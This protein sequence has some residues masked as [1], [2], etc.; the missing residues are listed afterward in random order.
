MLEPKDIASLLCTSKKINESL[1]AN[2]MLWL[3]SIKQLSTKAKDSVSMLNEKLE[4]LK[5]DDKRYAFLKG[6]EGATDEDIKKLIDEYICQ[7]KRL[8]DSIVKIVQDCK[9]FI[10]TGEIQF[11]AKKVAIATP[12]K[13]AEAGSGFFG[14]IGGMLGLGAVMGTSAK[15]EPLK[16][17]DVGAILATIVTGEKNMSPEGINSTLTNTAKKLASLNQDKMSR[18]VVTL[19]KCFATLYKATLYFY[20]EAR[21]VEKLKDFLTD[22]FEQLKNKLKDTK[23]ENKKL[24]EHVKDHSSTM[25]EIMKTVKDLNT[26]IVG[27]H[28]ERTIDKGLITVSLYFCI[29]ESG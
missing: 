1:A 6:P 25:N 7:R 20:C 3:H 12:V 17:E 13:P 15:A 2:R 9:A 28:Q 22:R 19:Q 26:Q 27:F 8:G 18:W 5:N 16:E 29:T 24:Q 23:E 21:D 14:T 10:Y 4:L 11:D